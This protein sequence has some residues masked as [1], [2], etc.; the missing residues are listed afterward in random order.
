MKV[1]VLWYQEYDDCE[2]IGV[3]KT[4]RR[5]QQMIPWA[6]RCGSTSNV[7]LRPRK[8]FEVI[9]QKVDAWPFRPEQKKDLK[10]PRWV[11]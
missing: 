7:N 6:S 11:R 1:Y 8:H 2:I 9:E 10:L 3:F 5:A 4:K